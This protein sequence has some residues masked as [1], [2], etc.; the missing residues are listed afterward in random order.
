MNRQKKTLLILYII[1]FI[2]T[3]L[4][5]IDSGYFLLLT[6]A[7]MI[8]VPTMI[9]L[10]VEK[11]DWI[12]RYGWL[13]IT[14]GVLS[15]FILTV[16]TSGVTN[17]FFS[18][19]YLFYT[20]FICFYGV[21]RF[22]N[23]GFTLFEEF[24]IDVGL[25]YFAIGG[26]WTFAHYNGIDTGFSPMITWLTSI[27]F[28]Y[29]SFLLPVFA[30]FLGRVLKGKRRGFYYCSTAVLIAP[31]LLAIGIAV[32]YW[33]EVVSVVLY[34]Y[35]I[36]GLI[37]YALRARIHRL[38]YKSLAV[39]SFASLGVTILFS[40]AYI[41]SRF[42]GNEGITIPFMLQFHG[43]TNSVFFA[44]CGCLAWFFIRPQSRF[45]KHNIPLS[46]VRGGMMVGEEVLTK[47]K[48][49]RKVEGL[50]E[51]LQSYSS[52]SIPK[53]YRDFYE[54][55][56][57]F[58]LYATVHWAKWF[59]P[60]AFCYYQVS[61]FVKQIHLPLHSNKIEMNG[62]LVSVSSK[63]DG[64]TNPRAWVRKINNDVCFIALYA[65]HEHL[66]KKY[67]NISLPLP[68]SAMTGIL[69]LKM[70]KE[71]LVLTS[72]QENEQSHEGIYFQWRNH[73][74]R[75]PLNEKFTMFVS[76]D[77]KLM[78]NHHMW[79]FGISFLFISY[80]IENRQEKNT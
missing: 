76:K 21:W 15:I 51:E 50:V 9:L 37:Y 52:R 26:L 18:T 35:G 14:I 74:F 42:G 11:G 10:I 69:S 16:F 53:P 70:D 3:L 6:V 32:S 61:R 79:I 73:F 7:Q 78:A 17:W 22:L 36:Y 2:I 65:A 57:E 24:L 56:G 20:V 62:E 58:R 45:V 4:V 46:H 75:L 49:N 12:D 68:F 33:L 30:G 27:H 48:D 60:F 13:F 1:L 34:I 38:F 31:L 19:I 59:K 67:I 43:I 55:T 44:L 28:H 77:D 63:V 8:Y 54:H 72:F 25:I 40:V 71:N 23:R 5:S 80:E 64:R 41:I 39:I 29:A 66:G 47:V